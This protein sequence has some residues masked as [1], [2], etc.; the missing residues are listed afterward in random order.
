MSK[1]DRDMSRFD[2]DTSISGC[3]A[4]AAMSEHFRQGKFSSGIVHAIQKAGDLLAEHFPRR[5]DSGNELSDDVA[6]D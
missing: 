2:H 1:L 6:R 5:E 4:A 3:D